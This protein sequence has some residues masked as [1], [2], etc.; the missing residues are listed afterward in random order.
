MNIVLVATL[1]MI[2]ATISIMVRDSRPSVATAAAGPVVRVQVEGIP[3]A[4]ASATRAETVEREPALGV[5]QVDAV[6][7]YKPAANPALEY[8]A[9]KGDTISNVVTGLLGSN[10]KDN[11]D[12][13]IAAN[14]SLQ[15]DP[16]R[17]LAGKTYVVASGTAAAVAAQASTEPR[18][19][20]V[21]TPQPQVA[22][23][24]AVGLPADVAPGSLTP[25]ASAVSAAPSTQPSSNRVLK[26]TA[27]PGDSVS[28]LAAGLL[29]E[30]SKTN[31]DAIIGENKS[32]QQDPDKVVSGKTYKIPTT[33]GLSA[34]AVPRPTTQPEA[35]KLVQIG[36]NREL[37]YVA[38]TGDNVSKLAEILLGSDTAAN[39]DAIINNN[40]PL[41]SDPDRVVVGETYWI[42]APVAV[43][44]KK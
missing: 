24:L 2:V 36:K 12:T 32:L 14:P 20:S 26:Y 44:E 4:G 42:P 41:K 37:R 28:A 31:R 7:P 39:R 17:V 5:R 38:R 23:A 33:T 19:V 10:T 8:T 1:V 21:P 18:T 35:D 13:V 27:Q 40:A 6:K 15:A 30:D 3:A 34:A 43:M 25:A 9:G 29:G 16:D 11:Q 22:P